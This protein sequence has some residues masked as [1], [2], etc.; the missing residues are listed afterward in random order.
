MP[1][2]RFD[3]EIAAHYD[4]TSARNIGAEILEPAVDFLAGLAGSGA[5]LELGVGTGRVALPLP[6]SERGV[7]VHGIDVS[8]PMLDPL[9]TRLAAERVA[10]TLGD[11]AT[12]RVDGRFRLAYLVFNTIT[13]LTTQDDQVA[14]FRSAAAHLLSLIHI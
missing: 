2:A 5:A 14:C 10:L 4:E 1:K 7:P 9:R 6:L 8:E 13:N 3:E 11:I 12:A